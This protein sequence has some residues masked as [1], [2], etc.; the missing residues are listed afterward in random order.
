MKICL[1]KFFR[2]AKRKHKQTNMLDHDSG[3]GLVKLYE[4]DFFNI[5]S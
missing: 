2:S 3:Y 1:W 5:W 4:T